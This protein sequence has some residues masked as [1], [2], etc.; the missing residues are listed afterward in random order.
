MRTFVVAA[1][2]MFF[3][4]MPAECQHSEWL[5]DITACSPSDIWVVGDQQDSG[6]SYVTLIKHFD[7]NTWRDWSIPHQLGSL[8]SVACISSTNVWAVGYSSNQTLVDRFDGSGWTA[9]TASNPGTGLNALLSV[10]AVS[11]NNIWVVGT[12]KDTGAATQKNL[13]EEWDGASWHVSPSPNP[14]G[15]F[16]VLTGVATIAAD[17]VWAVGEQGELLERSPPLCTGTDR[18]GPSFPPLRLVVFLA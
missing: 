2:L 11:P 14:S 18:P 5:T 17:N 1:L 16:S 9:S 13:I 10:G 8:Q 7:G 6:A 12:T 3:F 15:N 4:V